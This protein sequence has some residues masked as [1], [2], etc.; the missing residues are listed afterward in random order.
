MKTETKY[1]GLVEYE[2]GEVVHFPAG[3][4]AFPEEK[5][6]LLL[7]FADSGNMMLCLQSLAT[8]MLAFVLLD[9]FV[10]FPTYAPSLQEE[11][12]KQL[13]VGSEEQLCFYV[14]CALKTH[15]SESTVNL[16][17]PIAINP[18]TLEA[19][20]ILLDTDSYGMRDPLSSFSRDEGKPC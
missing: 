20:Q 5:Q 7:P 13:D 10:L 19:Y 2:Q 6:F 18:H 8:P 16:R 4:P 14:L 9:P 11:E 15:I 1:F 12:L 3:I 17:C